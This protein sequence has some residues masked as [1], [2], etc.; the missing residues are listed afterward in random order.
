MFCKEDLID[1]ELYWAGFGFQ[2][3]C[4]ML[5]HVARSNDLTMLAIDEP[6]I[7]LHPEVQH[8]LISILRSAGP[9][10]LLATHSTEIMSEAD[11]SEILL[12]DKSRRSA[13]RLKDIEQV[14]EALD[15]VGSVQVITLT[16]LARSRKVVFVED[17]ADFGVLKRFA[18]RLGLKELA[19]GADL[20]PAASEGF[21]S[22][23]VKDVAWGIPRTLGSDLPI[24][25]IFDRD[26]RS[27]EESASVE[28]ELSRNLVFCH[29]HRRKEIENY[30]LLPD[31]LQRAFD[32][33]V[34][35]QAARSGRRPQT[36][37]SVRDLLTEVTEDFREET[38]GQYV[39][40]R[41][42]YLRA[43]GI[44]AA[45][46]SIETIKWFNKRWQDLDRRLEIV[47][48][49]TVLRRIRTKIQGSFGVTLTD[50]R[51]I[52]SFHQDEVPHD[53]KNLLLNPN[54]PKDTDGRREES[55]R[56]VRDLQGK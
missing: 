39:A 7:Y 14:Q 31:P 11:P 56:G 34:K 8:K 52:S 47:P 55:G 37:V 50:Y 27:D 43:S 4:Q 38:Q 10:I 5:T 30:L 15:L 12:V 3:W 9:D 54:P 1:R 44:D 46:S 45:T 28:R 16:Q 13:Q 53:L 36:P 6:E 22:G 33:G 26:Y 32:K 40:K 17:M 49:K 20:T 35:E 48:G 18:D 24:A 23:R 51:I 29:I 42:E 2:V 41:S 19:S 21:T 25:A